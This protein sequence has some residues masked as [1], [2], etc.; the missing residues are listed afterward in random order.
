[1]ADRERELKLALINKE[2]IEEQLANLEISKSNSEISE[3]KYKEMK[4]AYSKQQSDAVLAIARMRN[5]LKKSIS[6]VECDIKRYNDELEKND[7]GY[8]TGEIK[9]YDHNKQLNK[10]RNKIEDSQKTV[11]ELK[12][13]VSAESS[14][15]ISVEVKGRAAM[16]SGLSGLSNKLPQAGSGS[17]VFGRLNASVSGLGSRYWALSSIYKMYSGIFVMVF[18]PIVLCLLMMPIYLIAG[19]GM[20]NSVIYSGSFSGP[21]VILWILILVIMYVGMIFIESTGFIMLVYGIRDA[22]HER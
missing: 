21:A 2:Y 10:Y 5:D 20:V 11:S 9:Q 4:D 12:K 17:G 16:P 22:W 3:E 15:D 8:K 13:L 1:M 18:G 6:A 14:K 19:Y 7:I